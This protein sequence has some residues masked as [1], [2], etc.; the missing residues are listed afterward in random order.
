MAKRGRQKK[1][2]DP[3]IFE[4]LCYLQCTLNEIA[5]VFDCSSDTIER[6]CLRTY[7]LKFAEAFKK[8]STGGKVSLRRYQFEL[9]KRNTAMAIFLGKNYLGQTDKQ[10][11]ALSV[12][13]DETIREM[14]EYFNERRKTKDP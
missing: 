4:N 5:N 6:W 2:I 9:A 8:Y 7:K 12:N 3:K 14:E 13:D 10:D 1:E 11:L